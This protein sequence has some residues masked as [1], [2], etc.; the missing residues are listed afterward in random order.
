MTLR[1]LAVLLASGTLIALLGLSAYAVHTW[2]ELSARLRQERM[3]GNAH[4]R[5]LRLGNAVDYV[6]L[7]RRDP[8]ILAAMAGDIESLRAALQAVDDRAAR[9][10]VH[11]LTELSHLVSLLNPTRSPDPTA[12]PLAT[13]LRVNVSSLMNALEEL[14][15][16]HHQSLVDELFRALLVFAV[17]AGL[18]G[19]LCVAGFAWVRQRLDRPLQK[20]EDGISAMTAGDLTARI[21]LSGNDELAELA[22][23]LNA[24]AEQ[25]Q[26]DEQAIRDSEERFRQLAENITEV[27]WLTDAAKTEMIY[28]SPSYETIWGQPTAALYADPA[29]WTAAIHPADRE[30]VTRATAKQIRGG[31]HEIY[32]IVRPDGEQR[33]VSDRAFPVYAD[34]GRVTR[35]AGLAEDVTEQVVADLAL[36]E[37]IKELGCL[38]RVLELTTGNDQSLEHVYQEIVETLP[39][40]LQH[41]DDAVAQ[42]DLNGTSFISSGWRDPAASLTALIYRDSEAIG[43]VSVGYLSVQDDVDGGEGPFLP[44][45]RALLDGVAVHI[46]R[47][48]TNR[49]MAET[50]DQSNRLESVGQLTGGVAHDFNNLLTVI[51]GNSELLKERLRDDQRLAGLADM[52]VNAAQRGAALTHR[53]LAFARRQPLEPQVLDVNELIASIDPLLRRTL[54]EHIEIEF[55]RAGG[56]WQALVDPGQLENA[57]L[58]LALNARDAM[59]ESGRLTIETAN[60]RLSEDYS[61]RYADL[62]PGQYVMVAVSDTGCGIPEEQIKRVFEPFFTTKEAGKGTGLGLSMVYG[63]VKQ[64]QGHVNVYS[65]PGHGTTVKMYL[66]RA[67]ESAAEVPQETAKA[68]EAGGNE[69]ILVVEDDD[70]VRHFAEEQ[71]AAMGYRILS[72]ATGPAALAVLQDHSEVD[73]LF[74]DVVMPGGRSGRQLADE[75]QRRFGHIRVLYTS[76]YTDNA[77]VHHGRLDHGVRL[78]NKPYR[79]AELAASVRRALDAA[80]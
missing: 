80:D 34:D 50:L 47:M 13:Q 64:S 18:F 16:E 67:L 25:R 60:V 17:G 39:T 54:G 78:L 72:A 52:I 66:P 42:I 59:P 79:R 29:Q 74:T 6:T 44:E 58:N 5:A 28:V 31:Y 71:L 73:L 61:T 65:E 41:D 75:V 30:R 14:L 32:R 12:G 55:T 23:H 22:A 21:D 69:T 3:I 76:G 51:I 53:L 57:L 1:R 45:E 35:L 33:W 11:H 2:T 62:T 36:R 19:L 63:F 48:L 46:S 56:L 20:L 77:I 43:T 8:Q 38:Y 10:A 24:M 27:F 70:L 37:R 7:L 9:T 68:D 15:A 40:S 26:S 4:D 49:H